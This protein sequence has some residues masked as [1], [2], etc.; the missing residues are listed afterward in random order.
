MRNVAT[1][2]LSAAGVLMIAISFA[3]VSP[4]KADGSG[5]TVT[6]NCPGGGTK[7]CSGQFCESSGNSV[8]CTVHGI[9][10]AES[11]SCGSE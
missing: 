6:V 5:C 3:V 9:V 1:W 2:I 8:T 10:T 7:S 11:G 4:V